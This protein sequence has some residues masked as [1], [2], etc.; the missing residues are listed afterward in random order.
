[1]YGGHFR[2]WFE[3]TLAVSVNKPRRKY[4]GWRQIQMS[5]AGIDF[6]RLLS[7]FV[8]SAGVAEIPLAKI[9]DVHVFSVIT[10]TG[11]ALLL[12]AS[13]T[14]TENET[15]RRQ[16]AFR[17]WSEPSIDVVLTCERWS[18]WLAFDGEEVRA[19]SRKQRS[20][21]DERA[22]ALA[23]DADKLLVQESS[24]GDL[25]GVTAAELEECWTLLFS[26]SQEPPKRT[27][28]RVGVKPGEENSGDLAALQ[29]RILASLQNLTG[30]TS[31]NWNGDG[32]ITARVGSAQIQVRISADPLA[33]RIFAP[34]LVEVTPTRAVFEELNLLNATTF[35]PKWFLSGNTV[36]AAVH[37]FG[38]AQVEE[39]AAAAFKQVAR[40][41]DSLDE[42][43]Q[44]KLGGRPFHGELQ[45]T[46]SSPAPGYL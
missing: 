34:V 10:E 3:R 28:T 11:A 23:V 25:L 20:E 44:Q 12:E 4:V 39:H 24:G 37:L 46:P 5:S 14:K 19:A 30:E 6:T 33:V 29:D 9:R 36:I 42:Q 18:P 22:A 15:W 17:T 7:E 26:S 32:A 1:M 45:P 2:N 13:A 21:W 16:A 31:L 40:I 27:M 41:A 35:I 8:V 38:L 43:L